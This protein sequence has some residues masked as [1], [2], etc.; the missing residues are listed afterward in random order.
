[1]TAEIV[2]ENPLP[3]AAAGV[4]L[5]ALLLFAAQVRGSRR[6]AW[7]S[8]VGVALAAAAFALDYALETPVEK[9][10][11]L[12]DRLAQAAVDQQAE[13]IVA[14][15]ADDFAVG[16]Y[17]KDTLAHEIRQTLQRFD[18]ERVSLNGRRYTR[19]PDR[20]TVHFVAVVAVSS[21]SV[22][23][24]NYPLRLRLVFKPVG[25]DWRMSEVRRFE[26]LGGGQTEEIPLNVR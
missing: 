21:S 20:V 17:T 15:L 19:E 22:S 14:A 25:E 3:L 11:A 26:V 2:F 13:P 23:V 24:P 8:L 4:V 10:D 12:L 5:T 9:I 18:I 16:G 6:L 7:A 1:M